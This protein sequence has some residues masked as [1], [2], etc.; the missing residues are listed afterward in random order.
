MIN[1]LPSEVV[2]RCPKANWSL[3]G[4]C[5]QVMANVPR[6]MECIEF[7]K[8]WGGRLSPNCLWRLFAQEAGLFFGKVNSEEAKVGGV[9]ECGDRGSKERRVSVMTP[10]VLILC[11]LLN[12]SIWSFPL[13]LMTL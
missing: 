3:L 2:V 6:S 7:H 8:P 5:H 11:C 4:L 1:G 13:S 12:T 9:H 10:L